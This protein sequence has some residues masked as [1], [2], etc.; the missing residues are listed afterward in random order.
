[1]RYLG[2]ARA[3]D[4]RLIMPDGLKPVAAQQGFEVVEIGDTLLPT[5]LAAGI[6]ERALIDRLAADVIDEHREALMGLAR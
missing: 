5:P 2:I 6:D 3:E 4:G 1:M